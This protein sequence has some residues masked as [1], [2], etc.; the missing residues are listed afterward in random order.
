[1]AGLYFEEFQ[2]GQI[3]RHA[4]RRTVTEGGQRVLFRLDT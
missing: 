4:I 2:V 3:F 1:V